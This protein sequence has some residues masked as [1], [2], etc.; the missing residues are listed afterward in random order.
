M[1]DPT[2]LP[3]SFYHMKV[4]YEAWNPEGG[5]HLTTLEPSSRTFGLQN[6]EK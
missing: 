6:Y 2:E 1:R 3:G 5:A 4:Q